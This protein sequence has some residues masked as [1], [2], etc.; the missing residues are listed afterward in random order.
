[1]SASGVYLYWY[2]SVSTMASLYQGSFVYTPSQWETRLHCN[3]V[4]H[5]LH[6]HKMIATLC[7]LGCILFTLPASEP[8]ALRLLEYM[9]MSC[10]VFVFSLWSVVPRYHSIV[11]MIIQLAL[12]RKSYDCPHT[13]SMMTSTDG[14]IVSVTDPL[15][16]WPVVPLTKASD[17]ELLTNDW[18][19]NRNAGIWEAL[20]SSKRCSIQWITTD[21][22]SFGAILQRKIH[23]EFKI[24]HEHLL[25]WLLIC[26]WLCCK[27]VKGQ[28]WKSSW[29]YMEF[30]MDPSL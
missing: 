11:F 12:R 19:N 16:G 8:S 30:N 5:S 10:T 3:F 25:T 29:A 2:I 28:A 1:M 4:F 14:S 13:N 26:R 7:E 15:W 27:H 17:T 21:L 20:S 24:V 22:W 23:V 18:T 9:A 6:A